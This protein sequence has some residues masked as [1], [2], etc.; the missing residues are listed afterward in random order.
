MEAGAL[1]TNFEPVKL[2]AFG[3]IS[4]SAIIGVELEYSQVVQ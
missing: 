3:F 4:V 2:V 1:P